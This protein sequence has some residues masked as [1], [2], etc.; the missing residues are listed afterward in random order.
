MISVPVSVGR[1]LRIALS[2]FPI[3]LLAGPATAQDEPDAD[4]SSWDVTDPPGPRFEIP[5]DTDEGTWMSVD[6]SPDGREIVFD[7]LGDLYVIPAEGGEARA[8]TSGFSWDMQPRYSPDGRFIA[9]TSDR[10]GGDNVWVM[11]RDGSDAKQVT[12]ESFRLLNSPTWTPD[13]EFIAARK[14]FTSTRSLGAGEIWLYHRTGGDGLQI[15]ERPNQQK[16]VGEPAFSADGKYLYY[17]RDATPGDYFE[18]DKDSNAGI[19]AIFRLDRETGET[20]RFLGGAGGAIRPTPSPDGRYMAYIRRV[21]FQSMLFLYD[22][23]SGDEWPVYDALERDLQ[24]TWA[25]HGVYPGIAWTPD[26]GSLVFWSGGK[27]RRLEVDTGVAVEIPFHV[28]AQLPALEVVRA[29]VE[30][31]PETFRPKMLRWVEVSPRGDRVAFQVLG[32]IY[33]KDLPNGRPQ[34]LT[35]QDDHFELYPTW[36]RDGRWIAYVSWDD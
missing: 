5:I 13:S 3:L 26:G 4:A 1:A 36:S 30:V 24:E 11:N 15:T 12:K 28:S 23:E 17:S 9:F 7:L 14:H 8:L 18:Y 21:R 10:A 35:R 33:V 22:M 20:D 25:V 34:R 29:E 19:Y 2:A 32:H 16:D 6:V 27:I 31:A